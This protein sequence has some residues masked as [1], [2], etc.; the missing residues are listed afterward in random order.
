[1]KDDDTTRDETVQDFPGLSLVS[2]RCVYDVGTLTKFLAVVFH[3]NLFKNEHILMWAVSG[4]PGYPSDSEDLLTRLKRSTKPMALYFGTSTAQSE[5]ET[6]K[7]YNRKA[8]CVRTFVIVLDDIGT[9]VR[10]SDLPEALREPTYIIETSP[11]NFQ[12]GYVLTVPID[13]IELANTLVRLL[14]E[15]GI[16]DG[17]GAMANKLVRL[18]GGVNG[19]PGARGTFKVRL[20]SI[21]DNPED[22]WT[23]EELLIASGV[24]VTWADLQARGSAVMKRPQARSVTAWSG[25]AAVSPNLDGTVDPVLEWMHSEDMVKQEAGDWAT[26]ECPWAHTHTTGDDTAG[27]SPLGRGEGVHALS[28]G[29]HCFHEHCRDKHGSDLLA[30][31]AVSGGP[32]AAVHDSTSELH[33]QWTYDPALDLA[34]NVMSKKHPRGIG[35]KLSVLK[36]E[37]PKKVP[38]PTFDGKTVMRSIVDVWAESAAR[39]TTYGE[40]R[41]P[42]T[43]SGLTQYT[44]HNLINLWQ[45]PTWIPN[46]PERYAADVAYF[47]DFI[48]YLVPNQEE[49]TFFLD[50]MAAKAQDQSFRGPA[51]LMMTPTQGTG[52]T[53]MGQMMQ[54][55]VGTPNAT[56]MNYDQ[57]TGGS[58]FNDWM[59][60]TLV[61][62]NEVYEGKRG[63]STT[64]YKSYERLKGLIEFQPT[65]A[66][67]NAKNRPIR[68]CPVFTSY[69]MFSNHLDALPLE[70]ADRRIYAIANAQVQRN[71]AY[72]TAFNEWLKECD[73]YTNQLLWLAS[74]SQ[75]FQEREVDAS[76]LL[77]PAVMN[78]TKRTLI[79]DGRTSIDRCVDLLVSTWSGPYISTTAVL[80]IIDEGA[81]NIAQRIGIDNPRS[82]RYQVG[83]ALARVAWRPSAGNRVRVRVNGHWGAAQHSP[84]VLKS[85]PDALRVALNTG[86]LD[87][88]EVVTEMAK[89]TPDKIRAFLL[90][91]LTAEDL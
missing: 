87:P 23:P 43:D 35:L 30:W 6:L 7:L 48:S 51:L 32:E 28:R 85:A 22:F 59:V 26:I 47:M 44:G 88:S 27:Y 46:T 14:Y 50:W 67:I 73:P 31:V 24:G 55:I 90:D 76:T 78:E 84:C 56:S 29:F 86:T 39:V 91:N 49:C 77:A 11:G 64:Y 10:V 52:R 58:A 37:Y 81:I 16:S 61:V 69:L 45:R 34:F 71:H 75:M 53:T 8:L 2:D 57:L 89:N 60:N 65:V 15:A 66:A 72:F 74:L 70:A 4:K 80:K 68:A 1:M 3:V 63:I 62:C 79:L 42:S 17:G 33:H 36:R 19:K 12:Y 41:D 83:I 38:V 21:N 82:L 25:V 40:M 13:D 20:I 5:P 54:K 18:P 9:K